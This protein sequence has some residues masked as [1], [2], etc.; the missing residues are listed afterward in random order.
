M[1]IKQIGCCGVAVYAMQEALIENESI[2]K[3]AKAFFIATTK[4]SDNDDDILP[5]VKIEYRSLRYFAHILV[6]AGGQR[7]HKTQRFPFVL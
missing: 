7:S 6:G 1:K 2:S 3:L 4:V 5:Q